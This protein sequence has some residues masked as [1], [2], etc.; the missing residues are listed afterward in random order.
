MPIDPGAE[1]IRDFGKQWT[2]YRDNEGYY[3]SLELFTDIF[4]PHLSVE[5]L[6][7]RRVADVGS[8]TGRIVS[9]LL[10][11]DVR[12]VVAVE[13]SRAFEVLEE[14]VGADPR[15]TCLNVAGAQLPAYGDLDYIFSIGVLHHVPNPREVIDAC[16]AALRPGGRFVAWVYG[17]EGNEA[18][19]AFVTALRAVTTRLP[20]A[21]VVPLVRLLDLALVAYL[22]LGRRVRLPL[23]LYLPILR[24]LT[25]DKR[26]LVIYD[27]LRPAHA[28]YYTRAEAEA[29]LRGKFDEV[30]LYH[31]RGYSWTVFGTKPGA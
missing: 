13:P 14:N 17:Y 12:E 9:M 16:R 20:H 7:G 2:T 29:L 24:R 31:R 21:F 15:V 26:R 25:P 11:A 8:G 1:T 18:Y 22:A 30:T 5:D 27:Q 4:G 19:V 3:G 6:R 10:A 23:H 28:R